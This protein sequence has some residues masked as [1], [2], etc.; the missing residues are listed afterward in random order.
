M[1]LPL[2]QRLFWYCFVCMVGMEGYERGKV[3][4]AYDAWGGVGSGGGGVRLYSAVDGRIGVRLTIR[5]LRRRWW[6]T[7]FD[8]IRTASIP[9]LADT[10]DLCFGHKHPCPLPSN[11]SFNSTICFEHH[12]PPFGLRYS[13][14]HRPPQHPPSAP[15]THAPSPVQSSHA[16]TQSSPSRPSSQRMICPG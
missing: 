15:P 2:H 16:Q 12:H 10:G 5:A 6:Q 13:C 4:Y 9:G 14:S 11:S 3:V 8:P 1:S 7:S